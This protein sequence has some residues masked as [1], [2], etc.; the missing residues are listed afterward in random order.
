MTYEEVR[1]KL[2]ECGQEQ[3]LRFY[4]E[5]DQ[6]KKD[7]LLAAIEKTDLSV[8]GALRRKSA[9]TR[10]VFS[11]LGALTV[12]EIQAHK[13]EYYQEGLRILKEGKAAAV[14]L[15]GGMGTRL[16]ADR[17][18]GT[19]DIGVTRPL[20]IF[21]CLFNNLLHY[22]KEAGRCFPLLVM[23]SDLNHDA[24]VSFL[25]EHSFFGYDPDE[26]F[27]FTQEMAPCADYNGKLLLEKNWKPAVSPNGNGGWYSSLVK[28]GLDQ[29]L[30][31]RGVEY[32]TVFGVDNVLAQVN[33]PCYL[34]AFALSGKDCAGKVV[35]KAA[36]DERVGVLCLEDGRPSIV[37]YYEM[38]DEMRTLRDAKGELA[39]NYG[40]ILDYTFRLDK[41]KALAKKD[42]P[43]HIVEKKIPY[44]DENGT[45][46]QPE[47]PNGYKFETLVLDMIHLMDSC[48]PYEVIREQEFAPIKNRTGIDSVESARALLEKNGVTL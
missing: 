42:L 40:V 14:L 32:L 7:Q 34:G 46:V 48:L 18:K 15:A 5:L 24:T 19:F 12:P 31:E 13:E 6:E 33:D 43:L 38:T 11:P 45:E 16:G 20:Y 25:T 30:E 10:G 3:L 44:I 37:E 47:A 35:K 4:D 27:F 29:V 9:D 23:T 1:R 17:P 28:A 39:Y 2:E 41:L 22:A 26:I 8:L 36:P 21:E